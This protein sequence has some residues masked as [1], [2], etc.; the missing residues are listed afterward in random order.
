M[1][2]TVRSGWALM[3]QTAIDYGA[4]KSVWFK[5]VP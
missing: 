5:A 2:V 1:A 3:L 4:S